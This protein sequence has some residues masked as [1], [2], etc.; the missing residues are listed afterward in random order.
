M[1]LKQLEAA[2]AAHAGHLIDLLSTGSEDEKV[3]L[4]Q[5]L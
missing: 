3:P 1:N 2:L 5:S 4:T